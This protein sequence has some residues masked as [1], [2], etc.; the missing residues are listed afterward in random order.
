MRLSSRILVAGA[1]L[2]LGFL[3][4]QATIPYAAPRTDEPSPLPDIIF[5]EALQVNSGEVACR[6]P[7]GSR[8]KRISPASP[9]RSEIN[10]TPELYAAA[11]P[12]VS[13]DGTRVA[14]SGK[15]NRKSPWQIWEMNVDGSHKHQVTHGDSDCLRPAY[16]PRNE[17]VYS[18]SDWKESAAESTL[19]V[20]KADGANPRPITFGPGDFQVETVLSEGRILIS[21]HSSLV[22]SARKGIQRALFTIRPDGTGL[23]RYRPNARENLI[24][25]GIQELQNGTVVFV[26]K[27]DPAS[28]SPGGMLARIRRG[29]SHNSLITPQQSAYWSA[30]E[31]QGDALIVSKA[32]APSGAKHGTFDLYAFDLTSRKLGKLLYHNPEF[33]SVEAAAIKPRP[34]ARYYWSILHPQHKT[35]RVICLNAYLSVDAPSGRISTPIERVRVLTLDSARP[36]ESVLGEAPVETDGSFYVTAPADRPLRFELLD[37]KGNVIRAQRSWVWT[38]PG[39]DLGCLG[40][41]DDKAMAPPNHWPLALKRLDTP[42]ALGGTRTTGTAGH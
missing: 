9:A 31:L 39:E 41:H 4:H 6:F 5:V 33:S 3:V 15:A 36:G 12:D 38:R 25:S 18:C 40:C 37:A 30:R 34:Q 29:S 8:L 11:D 13:A 28:P 14:F 7:R 35:G 24:E 42:I 21:A 17:I 19:F 10:L 22:S 16:L 27:D 32:N 26:V 20:A 2:L 1:F 23:T